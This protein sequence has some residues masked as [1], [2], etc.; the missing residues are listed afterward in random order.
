MNWE[1]LITALMLGLVTV[2]TAWG[3]YRRG[4]WVLRSLCLAVVA[5]AGGTPRDGAPAPLVVLVAPL[6]LAHISTLVVGALVGTYCMEFRVFMCF[7][8]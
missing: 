8:S 3:W 6:E 7:H 4:G 5:S 2:Y 1:G